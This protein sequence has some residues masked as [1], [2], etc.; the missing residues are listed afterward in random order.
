MTAYDKVTIAMLRQQL[1]DG[2][3]C[4]V[5]ACHPA[6][7]A[8]YVGADW[9]QLERGHPVLPRID[10][11]CMTVELGMVHTRAILGAPSGSPCRPCTPAGWLPVG[12]VFVPSCVQY[13]TE[14]NIREVHP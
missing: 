10:L 1:G 12:E 11:L 8:V 7:M 2:P 14:A 6:E 5:S 4:L 13:V 9:H 3:S